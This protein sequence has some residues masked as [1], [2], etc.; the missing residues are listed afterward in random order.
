MNKE[1]CYDKNGNKLLVGP[2]FT[3]I[4]LGA[5]V[6]NC[7]ICRACL[8]H[9]VTE[10]L[11]RKCKVKGEIPYALDHGES[12]KCESFSGNEKHYDYELTM[13]LIKESE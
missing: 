11:E 6:I 4:P 8:N 5:T 1:Y 10:Q 2:S 13:K 9:M 3:D 7:S 12:H